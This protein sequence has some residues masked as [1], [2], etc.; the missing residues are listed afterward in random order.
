[1]NK[2][3]IQP[4]KFPSKFRIDLHVDDDP[5]VKANGDILGFK[6]IILKEDDR[7]WKELIINEIGLK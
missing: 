2:T 3:E 5:S 4:S 7:N 1:M 6:V